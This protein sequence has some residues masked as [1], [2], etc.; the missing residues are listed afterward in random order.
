MCAQVLINA[1]GGSGKVMMTDVV[2]QEGGWRPLGKVRV[3]IQ[4]VVKWME[5]DGVR[6][7]SRWDN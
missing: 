5:R 7:C 3:P 1:S 6:G 2:V 4:Q